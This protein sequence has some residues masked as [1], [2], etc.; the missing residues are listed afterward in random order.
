MI[1][2]VVNARLE[3]VL[4]LSLLGPAGQEREVD[5]VVDTGFNGYLTLPPELVAD[6]G[7]PVVGDAEA[8]LADGSEAVFDVSALRC[9]GTAS[10]DTSKPGR[11]A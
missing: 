2:G 10:Q 7:L 8:V 1:E 11:L 6:L 5:V 4:S 3:A 9:S